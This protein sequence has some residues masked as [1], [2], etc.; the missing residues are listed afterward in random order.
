MKLRRLHITHEHP[1]DMIALDT[2]FRKNFRLALT[3]G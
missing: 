2:V 1:G 3:G